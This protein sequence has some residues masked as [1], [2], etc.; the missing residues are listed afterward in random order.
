MQLAAA[1]RN[2]A[3]TELDTR[4]DGFRLV[5]F[6]NVPHLADDRLHTVR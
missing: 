6:N 5:S 4:N 1:L 3:F 2:S